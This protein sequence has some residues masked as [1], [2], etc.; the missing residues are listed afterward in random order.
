MTKWPQQ[1]WLTKPMAVMVMLIFASS[2][3]AGCGPTPPEPTS[4]PASFS[5]LVRVQ[6]EGTSEPISEAKVK[7]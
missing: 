2:F 1:F 7:I 5:Y 6:A 4:T 3:V